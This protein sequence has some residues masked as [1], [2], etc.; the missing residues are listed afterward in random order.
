MSLTNIIRPL[1]TC[2]ARIWIEGEFLEENK[3]FDGNLAIQS[4]H[5]F[6]E[7]LSERHTEQSL[8]PTH[9]QPKAS[10]PK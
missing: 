2:L 6:L 10:P 8:V 1:D 3:S 7:P 4:K 9:E 5:S